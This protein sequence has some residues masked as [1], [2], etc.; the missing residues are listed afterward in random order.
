VRN[1][2][3]AFA[4]SAALLAGGCGGVQKAGMLARTLVAPLPARTLWLPDGERTLAYTLKLGEGPPETAVLFV[5]GS[6]HTSLQYYLRD[7]FAALPGNVLVFALQKRAVAD[8]ASGLGEPSAQFLEA[9]R[10][11]QWMADQSYFLADVLKRMP[12]SVRRV[13]FM[14]VSEGANVAA[15]LAARHGGA[16]HLV[17]IGSGGMKQADEL[18]RLF[19]GGDFE[20]AYRAIR[21]EP[22]RTDRRFLGQTFRYWSSVLWVEPME[23]YEKLDIPI[24][25]AMGEDDR[26]APILSAEFLARRFQEMGKATLRFRRFRDCDHALVDSRG[27]EHRSELFQEMAEWLAPRP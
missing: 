24:L 19:P 27:Q 17:I 20:A 8:R 11:E 3:L 5:S 14:G 12:A 13:V 15:C 6:G 21:R 18:P 23:C 26:S 1:R 2:A 25:L 10:F 22:E 7:Y 9:D 4:T 16:T